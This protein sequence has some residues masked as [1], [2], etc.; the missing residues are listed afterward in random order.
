MYKRQE[1]A[2]DLPY[3]CLKCAGAAEC[4]KALMMLGAG[5]LPETI[6]EGRACEGGCV[7]GPGNIA[8]PRVAQRS[9][10]KLLAAADKRGVNENLEK[11]DMSSIN[12]ERF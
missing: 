6:V 4:K 2:F 5:R 3:S 8:D 10:Q 12:M 1:E 9:R 7:S 11:I